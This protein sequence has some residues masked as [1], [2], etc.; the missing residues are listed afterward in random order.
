MR[1]AENDPAHAPSGSGGATTNRHPGEELMRRLMFILLALASGPAWP[2]WVQMSSEGAGSV[3]YADPDTLKI[4][5]QIRQIVELH[6]LKAPDKVR[7]HR[8]TR[9]VTEY[10]CK[11]ARIRLLQEEYFSGQMGAGERLGGNSEATDWF[12]LAHGTRG[13]NLMKFVCSR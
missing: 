8:S 12:S 10:D 5:G 1:K 9:V 2:G 7:G 11:E 4:D 6:D 13:W 3:M